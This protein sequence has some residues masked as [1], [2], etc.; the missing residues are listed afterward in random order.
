[1]IK[2]IRTLFVEDFMK[3]K[4]RKNDLRL[5]GIM[6]VSCAVIFSLITFVIEPLSVF[7][8]TDVTV[9]MTLLPT[10]V[11][12][13]RELAE[14]AAFAFCYSLV[15]YSA[16]MRSIKST[17]GLFGVYVGACALRRASVLGISYLTYSYIDGT[18]IFSVCASLAIEALMMLT[19]TL[20]SLSIG[21][22]YNDKKAQTEKAARRT[23]DLSRVETIDFSSVFSKNNPM[24]VCALI[25]GVM[26]SVI[27][28]I[29]RID[30]D[31]KY[32]KFYG[33]PNGISE[34]LVMI[35]YYMSDVLVCAIF[36]ALSWII[37]SNLLKRE[38][39]DKSF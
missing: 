32:T 21:K 2:Y 35:V 19:V 11:D 39:Q 6:A 20:I 26:L 18:D 29:M 31:I 17:W 8:S 22:K 36:Y 27:K 10:V 24:Q 7:A 28:L 9:S 37:L 13:I 23:G 1:M 5:F 34:I 33:A 15:I 16:I 4:D 12:I 38:A 25:A 14:N 3:N 30:L